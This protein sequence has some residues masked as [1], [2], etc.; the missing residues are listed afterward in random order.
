MKKVLFIIPKL[1]TGGTNSSLDSLYPQ[2]K[3]KY[4][5]S[6]FSLSH[7]PVSHSYSFNEVLLPKD[8]FLSLI[9]A[10]FLDQKGLNKIL[11]FFVKILR[12]LMRRLGMNLGMMRSKS[13]V[14]RL[15][16]SRSYDY[17]VAYQE[18]NATHFAS[19]FENPNKIAWIHVDYNKYLSSHLSEESLYSLFKK[20]V[21]VSDY[22]TSVFCQRYPLL[23]NRTVAIH[24]IIDSSR[25]INLSQEPIDDSRFKKDSFTI[26]SVGRFANVKRFSDVPQIA[27]VLKEKGLS[28]KWYILG[29]AYQD[30][31]IDRFRLNMSK[32]NVYDCVEWL[33]GKTNPY[34]Y[35]AAADLY[36]CVSESE[37]CP[38]V[39]KEAQIMGL[40]IVSTDFPSAFEFIDDTTGKIENLKEIPNAI[41]SMRHRIEHGFTVN[42][43]EDYNRLALD[44]ICKLIS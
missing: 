13:V 15:E 6:V 27:S 17:I 12:T 10:N 30:A 42:Y 37:A 32:Y 3:D 5:V 23:T 22:T 34:P 1:A 39:F 35:F 43:N 9:Y 31:E 29:P 33:G 25:I 44:K 18:G 19:L 26:L 24:N 16:E 20:I 36:V 4:E 21:S 28:F 7:H 41:I 40:P 8:Y 11:A 38:M 14:S 2:L